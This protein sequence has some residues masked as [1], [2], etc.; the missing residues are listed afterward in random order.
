M[1]LKHK[2]KSKKQ[3]IINEFLTWHFG[4]L[5]EPGLEGKKKKEARYSRKLNGQ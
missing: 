3:S 2:N 1:I 5:I 4:P